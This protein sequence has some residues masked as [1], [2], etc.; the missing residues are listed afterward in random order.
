MVM[1]LSDSIVTFF[2]GTISQNAFSS[3]VVKSAG[4]VIW[5]RFVSL[6]ADL[7]MEVRWS[8]NVT[9]CNLLQL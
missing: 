1:G 8:E 4:K 3:M 9:F 6:K 7:P 5:L 2:S